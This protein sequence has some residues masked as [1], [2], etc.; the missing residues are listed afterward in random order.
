MNDPSSRYRLASF[1]SDSCHWTKCLWWQGRKF[2]MDSATELHQ[3]N[4]ATQIIEHPP[5]Q[6]WGLTLKSW[7]GTIPQG[8]KP[9]AWWQV[10]C[11]GH[12]PQWK[13][14]C[15]DHTECTLIRSTDLF[16]LCSGLL[17]NCHLWADRM[18][19]SA[20]WYSV[21]HHLCSGNV[22]MGVCSDSLLLLLCSLPFWYCC[23]EWTTFQ[24]P[25]TVLGMEHC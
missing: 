18:A 15:L 13:G 6:L 11:I 8:N 7:H 22:T 5:C 12:L 16:S 20:S 25:C 21:Q 4:L 23:V 24:R 1:P 9:T 3:G 10:D 17:T 19:H 2:Y 14:Q